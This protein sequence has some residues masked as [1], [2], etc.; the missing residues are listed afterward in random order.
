MPFE[1]NT[2]NVKPLLPV[3]ASIV[4][5]LIAYFVL[6]M[7]IYF[8]LSL[9]FSLLPESFPHEMIQGQFFQSVS[10]LVSAVV[11]A[12]YFTKQVNHLPVS[13]LGLNF[14]GRGKDAAVGVLLA[15]VLYA[16]GFSASLLL[17][18]VEIVSVELNITVLVVSFFLYLIAATME[19]VLV[20]GYIQGLLMTKM[21]RFLALIISALLFSLLHFFNDNITFLS[22]LNLFLAGVMLGASFMYTRNL[23]FPI[24]LHVAWNWIQGSVLGYEVSGTKMFPSLITLQLPENNIINGGSFGF[25]GSIL[26]TALTIISAVLIVLYYERKKRQEKYC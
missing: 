26:C 15:M 5:F 2:P 14:K 4:L 1:I 17:G 22:F 24:M 16:I 19:E 3:W 12:V 8:V 10:G 7:V 25:E 6:M 13:S 11:C 9:T 18:A 20:R 23:C 21:N